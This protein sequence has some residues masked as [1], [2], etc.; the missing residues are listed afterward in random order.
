L[1]SGFVPDTCARLVV[2]FYVHFPMLLVCVVR[3]LK[4]RQSSEKHVTNPNT[5]H[6]LV[7][8]VKNRNGALDELRSLAGIFFSLTVANS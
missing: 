4:Q 5:L 2:H 8:N 7:D 1:L 3:S 6:L